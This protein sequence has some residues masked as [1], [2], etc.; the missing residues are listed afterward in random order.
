MISGNDRLVSE[1]VWDPLTRIWHWLIALS[2]VAGWL[3]GEFRNFSI[4]QWHFYAGYCTLGLLGFRMFWGFI[5]PKPVRWSTL[6][7][8]LGGIPRY[9]REMFS[10][11][12]SGC[13][14]HSPVGALASLVFLGLIV[15]QA[16]TGLFAE[17]DGLFY[18]GPLS[19][20]LSSDGVRLATRWH[21]NVAS[22]LLVM[23]GL[24]IGAMV[25]YAV[26]KK[27]NLV[28]AMLTG[29]KAVRKSGP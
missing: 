29:V 7:G 13:R 26:W 24:H 1:S 19:D 14:G 9:L 21:N 16:S 22:A 5:G 4:M 8:A 23:F 3:L 2:V 10:R 6:L 15:V 25:F 11:T 27:E 17:D 18:E 28:R 20:L 12:P